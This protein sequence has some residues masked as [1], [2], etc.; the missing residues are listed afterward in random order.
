MRHERRARTK[1]EELD[2][3]LSKPLV[4]P[5]RAAN[6]FWINLSIK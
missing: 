6:S 2:T 1:Q 5:A 4:V 3:T